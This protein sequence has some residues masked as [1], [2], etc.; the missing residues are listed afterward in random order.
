M[1]SEDVIA[2]ATQRFIAGERI[3]VGEI[4]AASGV[5]RSTVYRRF[6]GRDGLLAEVIWNLTSMSMEAAIRGATGSGARRLTEVMVGF[7]A[8]ANSADYIRTFLNREPERALRL[9]MTHEGGVQPRIIERIAE[10]IA[11]EIAA[12][13]MVPPLPVP[14]LALILVRITETFV[15]ATVISGEEPD[16]EKVRQA[17]GALLGVVSA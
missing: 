16:A 6:H 17:C 11:E 1:S 4:A 14:D 12:G 5:N 8:R 3:E 9:M 7:A 15:Y 10:V 13:S 2:L